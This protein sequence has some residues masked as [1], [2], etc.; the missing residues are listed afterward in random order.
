MKYLVSF[1]CVKN[2]FSSVFF[3]VF[4][5]TPQS[6]I[7]ASWSTF[8][9]DA[10]SS[11]VSPFKGPDNL[12][13]KWKLKAGNVYMYQTPIVGRDGTIY[14][15]KDGDNNL[16]IDVIY[17]VNKDGTL[18]WETSPSVFYGITH[19]AY[20]DKGIIYTEESYS[21]AVL[22]NLIKG[23]FIVARSEVDGKELWRRQINET[24]GQY[25]MPSLRVNKDGRVFACGGESLAVYDSDGSKVWSYELGHLPRFPTAHCFGPVLSHDEKTF[26]F[27]KRR[28]NLYSLNA[29][30]GKINWISKERFSTDFS[31]PTT[32]TDG[33][34]YIAHGDS[35]RIYAY[36]SE[37]DIKWIKELDV[38]KDFG[39]DL[40]GI[41]TD[42]TVPTLGPGNTLLLNI[43]VANRVG[44]VV[45]L[46]RDTG[47]LRWF[48]KLKENVLFS[49]GMLVD[50]R[51]HIYVPYGNGELY[52]L[53]PKG[54]LIEKTLIGVPM[55]VANKEGQSR[56]Y[57][58]QVFYS[59]MSMI[60]GGIYAIFGEATVTGKLFFIGEKGAASDSST[61]ALK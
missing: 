6:E 32:D 59:G 53:S 22:S 16:F 11:G 19:M 54:K 34:L 33:S 41:K 13:V 55:Q 10:Q 14:A 29:N 38:K 51:G 39:E 36:T 15:I 18:K 20:S 43:T 3:I 60:E 58:D 35:S 47:G 17:A 37:G 52:V 21:R 49:V 25:W 27:L 7:L 57:N 8:Q 56:R 26:Y 42:E 23:T 12:E 24:Y 45:A 5:L 61:G 31:T 28:G 4:I 50:N 40:V 44:F 2:F 1:I 9:G 48:Y 30:T 46:D